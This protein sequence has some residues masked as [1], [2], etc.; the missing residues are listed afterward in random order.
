ME[1]QAA[2][3]RKDGYL[4]VADIGGEL[5]LVAFREDRSNA[6]DRAEDGAEERDHVHFVIPVTRFAKEE[7]GEP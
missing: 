1:S 4:V 7:D 2:L 3:T 5:R 6:E